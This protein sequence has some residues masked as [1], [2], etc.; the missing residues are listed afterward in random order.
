[1]IEETMPLGI[2]IPVRNEAATLPQLLASLVSQKG[3][4]SVRC[5]AVVDG[6]SQDDSRAIIASWQS[7]LPVLRLIDN[8]QRITPVAFNLGIAACL[9][10][11]AEAILLTG[12]HSWLAADFLAR[13]QEILIKNDA[14]I[15]GAVHDYPEPTCV[16]ERAMQA[17]SESQLGRRL[18]FLSRLKSAT[19]TDI[20][21]C[22]TIRRQVFDRIGFFDETMVRNQDNDFTTRARVEGCRIL[23]DPRLRYTYLPRGNFWQHLRQMHGNGFWVGRRLEVHGFRHFAPAIFWGGLILSVFFSF[24]ARWR[25]EWVI[26]AWVAPYFLAI[27]GSTLSWAPRIGIAVL[28][29]PLLFIAGHA[30]YALGTFQGMVARVT[31]AVSR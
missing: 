8:P 12:A 26:G 10:A 16:F 27:G 25:W 13:L 24:L 29:L 9:E 31:P 14:D 21:P 23:T 6:R 5:L 11:G 19:P 18:R 15:I 17:F 30:A 1:M 7:Q 2:V 28:W 3:L 22:P 4:G 20:A